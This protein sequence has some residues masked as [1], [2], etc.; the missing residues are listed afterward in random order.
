M[1]PIDQASFVTL[2]AED[3]IILGRRRSGVTTR[4]LLGFLFTS[5][6]SFWQDVVQSN[7]ASSVIKYNLLNI[8]M[9][10]KSKVE[11]H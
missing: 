11:N 6:K 4:G 2:F 8:F 9:I 1:F 10:V 5:S 3:L 7:D